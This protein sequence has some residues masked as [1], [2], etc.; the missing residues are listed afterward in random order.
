M[1]FSEI[2]KI[3]QQLKKTT[4]ELKLSKL[5]VN[6]IY[7]FSS[8]VSNTLSNESVLRLY[9]S[10]VMGHCCIGKAFLFH[11]ERG[12]LRK[13]GFALTIEQK[14]E[15]KQ[16][17]SNLDFEGKSLLVDELPPQ[18]NDF[19]EV[20]EKKEIY[21][22][23]DISNDLTTTAVLGVAKKFRKVEF[24]EGD[25]EYC[26]LM[27]RFALIV[28]DNFFMF[29]SLIQARKTEHEL[30]IAR[31]IQLSLM[32]QKMPEM[33]NFELSFIYKP[34]REVGGDYFDSLDMGNGRTSLL[35]ADVEGK[36]LSA[37]LLAASSQA[38]F[39]SMSAFVD[40]K[41]PGSFITKVNKQ[42]CR[43]TN[44]QKFIPLVWLSLNDE[45]KEIQ[46]VN[47]GHLAPLH[48]SGDKVTSLDVGGTLTGLWDF[49]NYEYQTINPVKGDIIVLF[50]DGV[51]EAEN[52]EG[53]DFG[54]NR[55]VDLAKRNVNK[56]ANEIGNIIYDKVK[57]FTNG[58]DLNDDFTL[59]VLKV[60]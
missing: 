30:K 39:S 44:G 9:F 56:T 11:E 13:K 29:K 4:K 57:R 26:Y 47:A 31:E 50:T 52:L 24:N 5:L 32:P 8:A 28:I 20:L 49:I 40:S 45:K 1:S 14:K 23:I 21:L 41:D 25:I 7:E 15:F 22:L 6:S 53:E 60:K 37:A 3:E 43:F 42:I 27:S 18:F 38:V 46:S 55:I 34:L 10:M 59:I 2:E 12:L 36:G 58:R 19:K 16:Y 33:K 51:N 48:I 54:I 17:L 35:L